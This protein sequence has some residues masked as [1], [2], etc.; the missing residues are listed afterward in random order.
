MLPPDSLDRK[1]T[2]DTGDF[3]SLKFYFPGVCYKYVKVKRVKYGQIIC[4]DLSR[5]LFLLLISKEG[6]VIL[7]SLISS[8]CSLYLFDL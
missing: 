7:F 5:V 1:K 8:F 4:I 2:G 6:K 3:G